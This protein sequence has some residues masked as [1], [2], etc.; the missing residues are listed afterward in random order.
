MLP[1]HGRAV[2]AVAEWMGLMLRRKSLR[3]LQLCSDWSVR[4]S[5]EA[6]VLVA[7]KEFGITMKIADLLVCD[8]EVETSLVEHDSFVEVKNNP[9]S[10]VAVNFDDGKVGRALAILVDVGESKKPTI[11]LVQIIRLR[12]AAVGVVDS[13]WFDAGKGFDEKV[14]DLGVR[15]E[16]G[17]S[18]EEDLAAV[19]NWNEVSNFM[20]LLGGQNI[21]R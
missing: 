4:A 1:T 16:E 3:T 5:V 11:F 20:K 15:D 6:A 8:S 7:L 2:V 9:I 21:E 13:D 14:N 18:T 10:I 19:F 12:V 17:N